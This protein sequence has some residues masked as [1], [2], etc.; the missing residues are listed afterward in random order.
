MENE[1]DPNAP[2]PEHLES[3]E[4]KKQKWE[5]LIHTAI[6][7]VQETGMRVK[8]ERSDEAIL[9]Y[10]DAWKT[11]KNI[12][13]NAP[14]EYPGMILELVFETKDIDG[15]KSWKNVSIIESLNIPVTVSQK[16]RRIYHFPIASPHLVD[17][18]KSG[19]DEEAVRHRGT[20]VRDYRAQHPDLLSIRYEESWPDRVTR[21][22]GM[23]KIFPDIYE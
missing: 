8:N 13:Y 6:L 4:V 14:I 10:S 11:L 17:W 18:D 12:L 3:K 16:T 22:D 2:P 15:V 5:Q 20:Y 1:R 21:Q 9:K 23:L 7:V 19:F